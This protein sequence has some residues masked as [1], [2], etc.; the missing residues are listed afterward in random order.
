MKQALT[1]GFIRAARPPVTGRIEIADLRCAGLALRIT[2]NGIKSWSFRF[3]DKT[4][5]RITRATIGQYPAVGLSVAR[6]RADDMR[7]EVASGGNPAERKSRDRASGETKTFGHL[8]ARYV[9]EHAKRH[10]RSYAADERNLRLHILPHWRNRAYASIR[11]ADVIEL[12]EALVTAGK[13]TLANR[14]HSLVSKIFSFALDAELVEANPCHRLHK[15][16]TENV[17]RRI[18]NDSEIRLFW[19]RIVLP[20]AAHRTGLALRLALLTGARVSE[21]AGIDRAELEHIGDPA[22]AAWIIPGTRTKNGRDHLVPLSPLARETVLALLEMI[23]PRD[24]SLLPT[25]S[26]RR[27]GPMRGNSLTQAM[28]NLAGRLDGGSDAERTWRAESPSPHDLRR[29]VGTRLA[30]LR[31]PKEIRDRV[32]NHMPSDVGSVHYNLHDFGD[33][34]RE[35]LNRWCAFLGAILDPQATAAVV[36]IA[37]ARR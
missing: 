3:R 9:A 8:A 36:S 11:R 19:S 4:T 25:R 33:E 10:K 15:R 23:G 2:P 17:G 32:L 7:Q 21:V 34:K 24:Q 31:I 20:E 13:P 30:E 5:N 16:G 27:A 14:V 28:A 22:R 12:V 37:K 26:R 1:D 29:T 6:A 35:A 18:L